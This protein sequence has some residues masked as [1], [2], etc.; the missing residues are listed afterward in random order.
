MRHWIYI[1][2]AFFIVLDAFDAWLDL[3]YIL[4]NLALPYA[5]ICS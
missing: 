4:Q 1:D 2:H 5:T 3:N